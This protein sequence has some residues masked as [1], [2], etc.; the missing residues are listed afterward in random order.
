MR[1][2][3]CAML[4]ALFFQ[5]CGADPD[6]EL[7]EWRSV[8]AAKEA[9][10]KT[11]PA[12]AVQARQ[13][14]IDTLREFCRRYPAHTRAREVYLAA[15]LEYA[16][17]LLSGGEYDDAARFFESALRDNPDDADVREEFEQAIRSRFLTRNE[18]VSLRKGMR[19][20]EVAAHL[21]QPLPGW[22]RSITKTGATITSWYY[23]RPDGGVGGVY[24]RNGRLFAAEYEKSVPLNP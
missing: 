2:L 12:P 23:P 15:E 11:G 24:F 22:E 1:P 17:E 6:P 19:P 4:L 5:A 20:E 9:I 8:L 14:Y 7:Q 10:E 16:R 18:L 3:C 13:K 21:G